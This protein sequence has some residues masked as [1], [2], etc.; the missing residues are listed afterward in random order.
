MFDVIIH[1]KSVTVYLYIFVLLTTSIAYFISKVSNP[2]AALLFRYCVYFNRR[3]FV[4]R[5]VF[6]FVANHR[7]EME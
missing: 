1:Y 2:A 7:S 6:S 5:L 3:C 4:P